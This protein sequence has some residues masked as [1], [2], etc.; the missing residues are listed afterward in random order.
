MADLIPPPG[1][2]VRPIPLGFVNAFLIRGKRPIL[3]DT[4]IP[5]SA[6]KILAALRDEGYDPR[7]LSLIII[8]HAHTDHFGSAAEISKTTGAPVLASAGEDDVLKSGA[9]LP[10]VPA[11]FFGRIFAL[12]IGKTAPL[13]ALAV[14]PAIR[15]DAPYRL[16]AYGID[17][18]VIP[19]AGHTHGSLSILLADGECIVG[20]LVMGMFP[21]HRPGLP[22]FAEDMEA[23][24]QNIRM[25]T[26]AKPAIIYAG[27]GGP[28]SCSQLEALL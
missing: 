5:G 28:F 24:K 16:D 25:I 17:G 20:D 22:M 2:I 15:V 3:V 23:V 21:P 26:D 11:S 18:I 13:P 6:P 9:G 12:L 27:H 1:S 14:T 4:G 10:P 7:D 19:S 8:T